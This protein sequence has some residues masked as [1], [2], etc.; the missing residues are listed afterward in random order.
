MG[1]VLI[2]ANIDTTSG[3]ARPAGFSNDGGARAP[4]VAGWRLGED[5]AM[6]R[7]ES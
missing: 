6:A 7:A 2:L 1:W 3:Q 5:E 4:L